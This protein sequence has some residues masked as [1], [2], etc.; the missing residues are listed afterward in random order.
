M[1]KALHAL[2]LI[3]SAAALASCATGRN[4]SEISN[5]IPKLKPGYGRVYFARP[6]YIAL[7][8]QP[9]IHLNNDVVGKSQAGGFFYVDRPAGD[10][11][12]SLTT[13]TTNSVAFH[14]AGGETKYIKTAPGLGFFVA[15]IVPTIEYPEQGQSDVRNLKYTGAAL[16]QG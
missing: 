15:H 16:P 10:Y 6:D 8:I 12:V 11:T 14:L 13:E 1:K 2:A 5:T 3:A 9:Q 4:F 7:A